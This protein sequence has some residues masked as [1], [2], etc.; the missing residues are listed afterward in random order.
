MLFNKF[1]ICEYCMKRKNLVSNQIQLPDLPD[2]LL[3][4]IIMNCS[5]L[6]KFV[7]HYVSK[8][9]WQITQNN[10]KN[11]EL[12]ISFDAYFVQN[13]FTINDKICDLAASEGSLS[14]LKWI[15]E[16]GF[17]WDKYTCAN[18]ALNGHLD[19]LKWAHNNGCDWD[20][21]TCQN[22]ALNNYLDVLKWARKNGCDLCIFTIN[23]AA[24]KGH[25]EIVNWLHENGC[26]WTHR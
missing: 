25:F 9:F 2:E 7:V 22:A 18:A 19:I 3:L 23:S 13:G 26:L 14:I 15:R 10:D 4:L 21:R 6:T 12:G 20:W 1:Y 24:D 5:D 8:K 17:S 11:C 16:N